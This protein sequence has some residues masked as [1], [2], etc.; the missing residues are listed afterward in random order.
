[1]VFY[2]DRLSCRYV[3]I[4]YHIHILA[5]D[6]SPNYNDNMKDINYE[7]QIL[8]RDLEKIRINE[9]EMEFWSARDLMSILDYQR[10]ESFVPVIEKAIRGAKLL[11]IPAD[12]HFRQVPKMIELGKG[13]RRVVDDYLITRYGCYLIAQNG[14]TSKLPIAAAQTY[15]AVQT[16]RREIQEKDARDD[17]RLE[18]RN[19]L[20]E[21]E[22]KI[23][24][25]VYERGISMP[26][27]FAS[28]KDAHIQALYGGL[29][30]SDLKRIRK[31]PKYRALADFDSQVE[32]RAKDLALAMTAHNIEEINLLGKIALE[33]EVIANS[34]ATR[35]ALIERGIF[36]EHLPAQEDIKKIERRSKRLESPGVKAISARTQKIKEDIQ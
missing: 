34:K 17:A 28:F 18:A 6:I 35:G 22:T 27:E 7:L 25:V 29:S 5:N 9:G 31:I 30:T 32:L 15:F 21:T 14:D 20:K 19:K 1:M 2:R 13:A 23:A 24:Q 10:W 12:D 36:P 33:N 26:F 4:I 11:N 8:Q 3:H 16:R